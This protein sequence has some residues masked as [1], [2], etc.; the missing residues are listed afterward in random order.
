MPL[1]RDSFEDDSTPASLV[2][3][4]RA[5]RAS[6]WSELVER[7]SAL[8]YNQCRMM[9]LTADEAADVTQ[10]TFAAAYSGIDGFRKQC[11]SDSF[12]KWLQGVARNKTRDYFRQQKKRLAE[13][14]GGSQALRRMLEIAA[15][16]SVGGTAPPGDATLWVRRALTVIEA[17]FHPNTWQAF[18]RTAIDQQAA[19][20]V[21]EEL[22]MTPEA[23]RKAKSRVLQRLRDELR[24]ADN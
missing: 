1:D 6:A 18:W 12:R 23:V 17:D 7:Y 16:T 15:E 22:G 20:E 4:A 14:Q 10:E 13:A 19:P 9:G 21:A 3:D 2:H 5:N 11:A 24:Q 8:V